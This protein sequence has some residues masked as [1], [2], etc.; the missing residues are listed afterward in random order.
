VFD[1]IRE[2]TEGIREGINAAERGNPKEHENLF[3]KAERQLRNLSTKTMSELEE[4]DKRAAAM[5]KK[6]DSQFNKAIEETC[7][8]NPDSNDSLKVEKQI[9][10][11]LDTKVK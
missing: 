1:K 8:N 4:Y 3:N 6:I 10:E 2:I 9:R 11:M 5:Q 7:L